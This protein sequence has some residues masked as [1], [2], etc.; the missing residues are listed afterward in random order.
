MEKNS[1]S[2]IYL[3]GGMKNTG[4]KSVSLNV[5]FSCVGT[6]QY[7]HQISEVHSGWILHKNFAK[8][9]SGQKIYAD[10]PLIRVAEWFLFKS[11]MSS[12]KLQKLCYYAYCWFIVLFNDVDT[13]TKD[14]SSDIKVLCSEKFQAWI[15]GPASMQLYNRYKG[16]GWH[17]IPKQKDKPNISSEL[18]SLLQQVWEAYG[19]FTAEELE[20]ISH[21][22]APWLNARKGYKNGDACVNEISAYDIL[23]YYSSLE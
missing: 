16:Y 12:K 3:P 11:S 2:R 8:N 22:E 18:E 23:Q 15:H 7:K 17:D 14:K 19:S 4:S 21:R 13:I 5:S 20:A 6:S 1:T 10:S 9:I